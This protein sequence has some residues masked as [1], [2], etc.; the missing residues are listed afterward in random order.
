MS[1]KKVLPLVLGA[2]V[3]MQVSAQSTLEGSLSNSA[4]KVDVSL[5][6]GKY[7]LD[8]GAMYHS[9]DGK[10]GY[11]GAHIEDTQ[12]SQ[13]YPVNMGMGARFIAVDTNY[14][15]DDAGMAL[16][17]GGFYRY[18]FPKANRFSVVGSLYYAPKVLSFQ[19]ID[20]LYQAEIRGE[21]RTMHNA[22]VFLR[23]GLTSV[24][25]DNYDE[26]VDMNKSFGIG[27]LTTF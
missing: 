15:V 4:A 14:E 21:Y 2:V 13:D 22:K 20:S 19:N 5:D 7:F 6:Q 10:Y 24:N 26:N 1:I 25:L 12:R 9:D 27:M 8:L 18:T 3:S 11:I 17:L 16:A 23:Y